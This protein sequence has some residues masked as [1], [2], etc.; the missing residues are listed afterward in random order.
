MLGKRVSGYTV[1]NSVD[2][3]TLGAVMAVG[4]FAAG[5]RVVEGIDCHPVNGVA[6]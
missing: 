2:A 4:A 6:T 3:E 5:I 1:V